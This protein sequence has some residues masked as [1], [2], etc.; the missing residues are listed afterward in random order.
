MALT[1]IDN[2]LIDV[3]I[4]AYLKVI[5]FT[6][7]YATR[8]DTVSYYNIYASVSIYSTSSKKAVVYST[9]VPIEK[10][11]IDNCN[12]AYIYEYL[13]AHDYADWDDC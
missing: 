11:A 10:V 7:V 3:T 5:G 13:K 12:I 2:Q 4:P 9:S 1:K 6:M 8:I